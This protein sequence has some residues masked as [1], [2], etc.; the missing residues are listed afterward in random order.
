M[1][2]P[3]LSAGPNLSQVPI[4]PQPPRKPLSRAAKKYLVAGGLA[5]VVAAMA[6]VA[7]TAIRSHQG[8]PKTQPAAPA[9]P[10]IR[11][12]TVIITPDNGAT[13]SGRRGG[14]ETPVAASAVSATASSEIPGVSDLN[15]SPGSGEP[16][17]PKGEGL[18]A[19]SGTSAD[20]AR[21]AAGPEQLSAEAVALVMQAEEKAAAGEAVAARVLYTQ[22]L[23]AH[24]AGQQRA[25]IVAKLAEL[26]DRTLLGKEL[27]AG[28]T[29]AEIYEVKSGDRLA[30]VARRYLIPFELVKRVN[31]LSSDNL[32]IGQ[33]L[34]M[35][36]GPFSVRVYKGDH[37]LELL[38]GEM[39]VKTF[40]VAIG[41]ENKTPTGLYPIVK[42]VINPRFDPT[43]SEHGLEAKA[44]GAADNPIGTRW[45]DIGNHLGIHGTCDPASIGQSVSFGCIRLKNEDVEVLYDFLVPG[46]SK[47]EIVD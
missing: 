39:P 3:P 5:V 42:K 1:G 14:N 26:C 9:G 21:S 27:S 32:Q 34:K 41:S 46:A 4:V 10:Q 28:E 37:R 40:V 30:I 43:A 7:V 8:S 16:P 38:L 2:I 31:G 24:P 19:G 25:A 11:P 47:V 45:I 23:A 20:S 18:T 33:K 36:H 22:A 6:I 15:P 13:G 17:S 35:I 29:A 12:P 44:G